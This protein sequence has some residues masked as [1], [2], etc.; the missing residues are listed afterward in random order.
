MAT[1]GTYTYS[2]TR[3]ACLTAAF[4]KIN[5]LGDFQTIDATRIATGLAMLEPII[6]SFAALGMPLWAMTEATIALSLFTSA[7]PVLIGLGQTVNTVAPIRVVQG[8]RKDNLTGVDVPL[9]I[10]TYEDYERLSMKGTQT[11]GA[12]V[13]LFYQPLGSSGT[14]LG[15]LK[16]WVLPDTYWKTNGSLFI[17]YQRPFQDAGSTGGLE[18]D[19][20]PEWDMAIIY[21]LAY[22]LAPDYGLDITQRQ[23]LKNDATDWLQIALSNQTEEG[24]ICFQPSRIWN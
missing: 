2:L 11:T 3:D 17:R 10:Y 4:R 24:S 6:K 21:A 12:P 15:N 8:L 5:R 23:A 16:V 22:A 7:S 18:L 19:F 9:N 13:H 14:F 1:S 20:P